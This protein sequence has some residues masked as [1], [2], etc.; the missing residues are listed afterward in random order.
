M[1][2]IP[3]ICRPVRRNPVAA[4]LDRD[5]P[6]EAADLWPEVG[7]SNRKVLL[8][9]LSA[10]AERGYHGTTT[11]EI[12]ERA[13]MSPAAV[14][15]HYRSKEE[16]LY[17]IVRPGHVAILNELRAQFARPATPVE[18]LRNVVR[19]N[20]HFHAVMHT[21][22]RVANYELDALDPKHRDVIVTLRKSCESVVREAIRLGVEAG[23]FVVEDLQL[24]TVALVSLGIDV[25]RWYVPGRRLPASA[26]ADL[27]AE[28]ALRMVSSR[29]LVPTP[30]EAV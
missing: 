12:A 7:D 22:A 14:Y 15:T 24:A 13:G 9:A 25:A 16:L 6:E 18:R 4:I 5:L 29:T 8:A 27:Y 11:R 3:D 21:T 10:F 23:D 1:S 26:V 30:A 2:G 19:S 20:V 17:Q 28:M